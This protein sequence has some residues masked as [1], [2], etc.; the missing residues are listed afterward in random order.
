MPYSI[1]RHAEDL[2]WVEM[3]GHLALQQ[4]ECYFL[5]M[6]SLL[7]MSTQ[8]LDL[9]VDG[10]RIA[11][12]A[13]GARR[14]T[15]Q[16]AHHPNMGHLAFVVNE[17]HLLL[18]APLVKLVSGVGLFGDEHEALGYL[19][20]ARGRP[21]PQM[22]LPDLPPHPDLD[23]LPLEHYQPLPEMSRMLAGAAHAPS[24][25][26]HTLGATRSILVRP[27]PPLP[28][29]RQKQTPLFPYFDVQGSGDGTS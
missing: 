14:R 13:P 22:A 17:H 27:L 6:W 25:R 19:C 11:G 8:P 28:A 4:A 1:T 9:L 21:T 16:V 5:E 23:V 18:F 29:S 20:A 7:D 3:D 10:R 2:V 24:H 15:E 26:Q 12:A